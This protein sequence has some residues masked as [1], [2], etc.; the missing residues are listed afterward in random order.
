MTIR[1]RIIKALGGHTTDELASTARSN[2]N[3][4]VDQGYSQA[5]ARVVGLMDGL[6]AQDDFGRPIPL[7]KLIRERA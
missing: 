5:K 7:A 4:G 3:Y 2:Y 1:N 6:Y